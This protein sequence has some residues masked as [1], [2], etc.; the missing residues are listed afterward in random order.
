MKLTKILKKHSGRDNTGQVSVRHQGGR[1]KRRYRVI[2]F[3]RNKHNIEG[4]IEAIEY[5]PNRS[6][7][8]AKVLYA[9][10]E[11]RYIIKPK[12]LKVGDK[13]ES[14][15]NV[16]IKK[17]NALPL[18]KI[19]VGTMVHNI[20]LHSGRGGVLVRSAGNQAFIASREENYVQVK[21]PSGE[22]RR[23]L[24]KN[25]ATI[26]QLGNVDVKD[27]KLGKAGNSRR[28]GIRPTV[29]GVAMNPSSHPHGGGEG[30]SSVGMKHP[31]TYTGRKA[32]GNTRKTKKYSDKYIVKKR[33]K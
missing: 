5:D 10:G 33:G 24:G 28:R 31:K 7:D 16:D 18:S 22:I 8:I 4:K 14:G 6:V 26:G 17:G 2:D 12:G 15:D 27:R 32:V 11:R 30:R 25:Y 29:R 13:I 20:E 9:D 19:P 23:I 21:M 3:K 1:H